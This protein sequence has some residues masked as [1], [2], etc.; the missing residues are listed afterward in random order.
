MNFY[1]L[2]SELP[3]EL[4]SNGNGRFYGGEDVLNIGK[5]ETKCRAQRL[6]RRRGVRLGRENAQLFL[7]LD[8]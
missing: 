8:Y 3:T 7:D 2:D 1:V 5:R 4:K 6:M